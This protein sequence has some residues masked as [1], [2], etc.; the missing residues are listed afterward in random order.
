MLAFKDLVVHAALDQERPSA[1]LRFS[2]P[3]PPMSPRELVKSWIQQS[4]KPKT[5]IRRKGVLQVKCVI[6]FI[7]FSGYLGARL[8]TGV[9][10]NQL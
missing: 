10:P 4:T 7:A 1:P 5:E 9:T 3:V 6:Q 8:L 2:A